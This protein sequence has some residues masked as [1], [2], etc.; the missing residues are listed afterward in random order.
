MNCKW[1][2][3]HLSA[4][5]DGTLDPAVRDE[6]EAHVRDCSHCEGI[7]DE[8]RHFD[9]LVRDLPRYE[10]S[11][12]LRQRIFGSPEFAALLYELDGAAPTKP[13]PA[14]SVTSPRTA[15]RGHDRP[16]EPLPIPSRAP[17]GDKTP[18]PLHA[19]GSG[20]EHGHSGA[21]P[22]VRVALSA[23]AAV[24]LVAG[25]ALLLRQGL[26]HSG[27]PTGRS[28]GISN[29]G[30]PTGVQ[31]LPVGMR[32]IFERGGALWSAPEHG[33]GLAKQLTPD[34][35]TVAPGW[36]V[37]PASSTAGGDHV[38]YIDLKTGMLHVV[39]SDDQ[40]DVTIGRS[41]TPSGSAGEAFWS[42][43][44]GQ[45]ILGGLSW[46][47]NGSALAYLADDGT[48]HTALMI[49]PISGSSI[50]RVTAQLG[51]S[52]SMVRWSADSARVA[53]VQSSAAGQSI[54]DYNVSLNQIRELSASVEPG[55]D[56]SAVVREL[57]WLPASAG[58]AVTWTS[59]SA[60]APITGVYS[61]AIASSTPRALVPAGSSF[62]VGDF[63]PEAAG[64]TW[65]LG[66]ASGVYSVS[67]ATGGLQQLSA[68]PAGVSA[69][70]W[71]PN[72]T[73][74][75]YLAG[76]GALYAGPSGQLAQVAS[77]IQSAQGFQWSPDG[78]TLAFVANGELSIVSAGGSPVTVSSL[79]GVTS[80]AW[81]PDGQSLAV[82]SNGKV[83]LVSA[84]GAIQ[85]VVDVHSGE[86]AVSWSVVR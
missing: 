37:V 3:G 7:L 40:H 33:A 67:G 12:E 5:L 29:V 48:G 71:S 60:T 68:V 36:V 77:G 84:T 35:V 51:V 44:E 69:V 66:N 31:P 70:S 25:S 20:A 26:S 72:G 62:T 81:A 61:M 11:D 1:A 13:G 19:D 38:A 23:A 10:P 14:V 50:A 78:S 28:G 47:P 59:G 79:S 4:C 86:G 49:A 82:S 75:A 57:A 76:N 65:L 45:S 39:R 54:W 53:F 2:E 27:A 80:F 83:A 6:V 15:A 9:G 64:G 17:A 63:S 41:L 34:G 18:T 46:A 22:W 42:G 24:V 58:P 21:P 55:G 74:A 30:G 85:S 52:T 73:S 16:L 43:A 56:A 32:V 8:Y